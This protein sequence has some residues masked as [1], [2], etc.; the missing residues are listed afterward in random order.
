MLLQSYSGTIGV[1]PAIPASWR[2]V[3]FKG[4][5]A[6]GAFIVSA[7]RKDGRTRSI[8][9]VAEAGGVLCLENPLGEYGYA[10]TGAKAGEVTIRGRDLRLTMRPDRG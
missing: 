5:R 9:I 1:F 2:D 7:E 10:M 4:R 3:S 8:D 6:E